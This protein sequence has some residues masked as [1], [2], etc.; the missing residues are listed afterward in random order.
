MPKIVKFIVEIILAAAVV[1]WLLLKYPESFDHVIPW[2][3]FA[4]LWHMTWEYILQWQPIRTAATNAF[5]KGKKMSWAVVMLLG[6]GISG[7]IS[8]EL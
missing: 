6:A 1:G 8:M 5:Q 7:C 4:I 2:F 3:I